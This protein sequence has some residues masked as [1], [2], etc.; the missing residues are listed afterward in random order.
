MLKMTEIAVSEFLP[1]APVP[2]QASSDTQ[3]I[4][5][6]LHGRP[7]HTQRAYA[8]DIAR[9]CAAARKPLPSVTLADLQ[10]FADSL[11]HLRRFRG[12]LGR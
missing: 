9:I 4:E 7:A 3:L 6:W 5:T 12:A 2:P 11:G 8:G 10:S 1:A